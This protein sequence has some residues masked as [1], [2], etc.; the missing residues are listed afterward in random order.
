MK[1]LLV[2]IVLVNLVVVTWGKK[3]NICERLPIHTT[4]PRTPGDGGFSILV[5]GLPT[6][7]RYS[8]GETYTGE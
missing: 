8:P 4:A 1:S 2:Q 5:K 3:I 6:T 7:G